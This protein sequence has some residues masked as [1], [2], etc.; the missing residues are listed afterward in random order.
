MGRVGRAQVDVPLVAD[1]AALQPDHAGRAHEI[2]ARRIAVV[3]A[4]A[5]RHVQ[6]QRHRVGEGQLHLAVVAAGAEDAQIRDQAMTR[7]DQRHRFLRREKAVLVERLERRQRPALA[8]QP[9]QVFLRDV[10][11]AGG[12]VDHQRVRPAVP[13][14]PAPLPSGE[15]GNSFSPLPSGERGR[16]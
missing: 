16:G 8:E 11:V 12:D 9:L 7:A 3:A 2:G 13:L 1:H 15:R 6:A 14:T 5:H 10:T 4:L